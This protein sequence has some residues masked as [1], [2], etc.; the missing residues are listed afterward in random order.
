MTIVRSRPSLSI[1]LLAVATSI[2]TPSFVSGQSI[3]EFIISSPEPV[4]QLAEVEQIPP[5]NNLE[6]TFKNNSD[7]TI[8]EICISAQRGPREMVCMSGFSN[9]AKLRGPG[10]TFSMKFDA[11][12]F[13]FQG[14]Q[15]SLRV[16]AVVYTDGSHFGENSTL[17]TIASRMIGVTL[18][19][20]HI[21]D[22]LSE[23]SDKS[24]IGLD[25]VLSQIGTA[26]PL[27][28]AEAATQLKGEYLSGVSP[29]VINSYLNNP[30]QGFL[31]GV[32]HARDIILHDINDKKAIAAS[33]LTGGAYKRQTVLEARLNGLS[34]LAQ[35][36]QV[37]LQ[38]QIGYLSSFLGGG[39]AQ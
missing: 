11:S 20:K 12:G 1:A 28:S 39:N 14:Q 34:D 16:N 19:T 26:P 3:G 30:T 27:S 33:P 22:L 25:G 35:K 31:E 10:D 23:S 24:A 8:L 2:A 9:G 32:I 4:I 5:A 18:E 29:L 37:L 17:A 13:A 36:C 15:N 7:H 38:S 21:S 6:F